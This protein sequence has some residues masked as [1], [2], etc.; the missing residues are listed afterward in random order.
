[1][2]IYFE[3][4][5]LGQS[6]YIITIVTVHKLGPKPCHIQPQQQNQCSITYMRWQPLDTGNCVCLC[7]SC[8]C[9]TV[10]N[11]VWL[12]KLNHTN[13]LS[14]MQIMRGRVVDWSEHMATVTVSEHSH[15]PNSDHWVSSP[16]HRWYSWH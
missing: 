3:G 6:Q 13:Y 14:V 7:V 4:V 16:C 10:T 8:R 2:Y 1:M 9:S 11:S 5:I 15:V 12:F